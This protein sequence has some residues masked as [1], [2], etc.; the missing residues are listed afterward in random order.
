MTSIRQRLLILLLGLWTTVWLAVALITL[1]RSGHEIAELLDAQLAQTARVLHQ[2]TLDGD[3]PHREP[4]P[5]LLSPFGHPYENK[6]SYQLWRE[7]ELIR[8]F[9]GAPEGRLARSAGFSDQQI[10]DTQWRVFGLPTERPDEILFV[11]QSYAI[12]R[13]LI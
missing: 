6:I 4:S 8:T 7:G 10:G 2:L 11:A 3:L 5:Q 13:E 12:R 1:D 9:G